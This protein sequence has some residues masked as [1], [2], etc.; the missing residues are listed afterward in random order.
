MLCSQPLLH[1][2][3]AQLPFSQ[4]GLV[5]ECVIRMADSGNEIGLDAIA[6]A[7]PKLEPLVEQVKGSMKKQ[8]DG[9]ETAQ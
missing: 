2:H 4:P 5:K 7:M 1:I 6:K 9:S 3:S 8:L